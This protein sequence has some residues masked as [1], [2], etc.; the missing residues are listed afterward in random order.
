MKNL[1][2]VALQTKNQAKVKLV[3][4]V[5][6]AF[7]IMYLVKNIIDHAVKGISS[8]P[9]W[10]TVLISIVFI[11][12]SIAYVFYACWQYKRTQVV[13]V[14]GCEKNSQSSSQQRNL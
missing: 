14:K 4:R 2:N 12:S 13:I 10:L 11:S 1:S 3:L 6:V 5:L 8:I 7:Y 9:V